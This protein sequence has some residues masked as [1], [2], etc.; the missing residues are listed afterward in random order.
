ME[1]I[2]CNGGEN[3]VNDDEIGQ[4]HNSVNHY[5]YN[6]TVPDCN[7]QLY[8]RNVEYNII[9]FSSEHFYHFHIND[10]FSS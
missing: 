6:S 2:A 5:V 9:V 3:V 8:M 10:A 7:T 1:Q 4:M